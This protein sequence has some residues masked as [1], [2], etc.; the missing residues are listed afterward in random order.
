MATIFDIR[1]SISDMSYEEQYNLIR[2]LRALRRMLK[3]RKPPKERKASK[4]RKAPVQLSLDEMLAK[5]TP[6]Q[7]KE[8][9]MKLTKKGA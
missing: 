9:M 2:D 5:M 1:P 8:L 7:A 4:S 3:P 6:E